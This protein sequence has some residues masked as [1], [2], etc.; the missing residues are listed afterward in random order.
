MIDIGNGTTEEN[1][2]TTS[3]GT[4]IAAGSASFDMSMINDLANKMQTNYAASGLEE[5]TGEAEGQAGIKDEFKNKIH[6]KI[7]EYIDGISSKITAFEDACNISTGFEGTELQQGINNLIANLKTEMEL[8]RDALSNAE[9]TIIENIE[10]S[11]EEADTKISGN[12]NT[13]AQNLQSA[14]PVEGGQTSV[15]MYEQ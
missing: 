11:F 2:N 5:E 7:T 1:T 12:I 3:F 4:T 8:Y 10:A 9:K 15:P 14:A 6:D 13:H